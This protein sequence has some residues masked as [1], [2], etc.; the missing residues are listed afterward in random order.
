M[1]IP[2]HLTT[3]LLK[4]HIHD[5]LFQKIKQISLIEIHMKTSL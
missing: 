2:N 4:D 3:N 5:K 1:E